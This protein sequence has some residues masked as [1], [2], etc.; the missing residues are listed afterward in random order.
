M[1]TCIKVNV[2]MNK[3]LY[4][5]HSHILRYI[6]TANR[7]CHFETLTKIIRIFPN[8]MTIPIDG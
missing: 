4:D 2:R 6:K 1:M 5:I 7:M 8:F 3:H